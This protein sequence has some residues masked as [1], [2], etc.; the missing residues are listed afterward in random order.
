FSATP[1]RIERPAPTLGQHNKNVICAR[2][3]YS[4]ED[5]V[6]MRQLGAI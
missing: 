3:G 5:M 6:K 2:L 1:W 4:E